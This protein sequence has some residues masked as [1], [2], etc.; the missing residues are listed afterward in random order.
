VYILRGQ[1]ELTNLLYGKVFLEKLTVAH[2]VKNLRR[3]FIK[4]KRLLPYSQKAEN[5]PYCEPDASRPHNTTPFF[6]D[7]FQY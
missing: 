4:P 6:A 5:G 2:L 3:D 1:S 7:Y